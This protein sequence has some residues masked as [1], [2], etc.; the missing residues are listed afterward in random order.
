VIRFSSTRG[1]SGCRAEVDQSG[2]RTTG[3]NNPK[4]DELLVSSSLNTSNV[5]IISEVLDHIHESA[6]GGRNLAA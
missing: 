3:D 1:L 2:W 6:A 5:L 4:G